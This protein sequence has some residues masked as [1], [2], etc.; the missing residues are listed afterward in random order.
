MASTRKRTTKRAAK[1]PASAEATIAP[2][3]TPQPEPAIEEVPVEESHPGTEAIYQVAAAAA[4]MLSFEC[5]FCH[6]SHVFR[7]DGP[8]QVTCACGVSYRAIVSGEGNWYIEPVKNESF[9]T[10]AEWKAK[11]RP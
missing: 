5:A 11:N 4:R 10:R 2:V 3:E 1:A 6:S 7:A 9:R 8:R